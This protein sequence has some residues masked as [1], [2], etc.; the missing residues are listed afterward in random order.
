MMVVDWWWWWIWFCIDLHCEGVQTRS[1]ITV[2]E[3]Q[4]GGRRCPLPAVQHRSC[5]YTECFQWKLG[6]WKPCQTE[7]SLVYSFILTL[8]AELCYYMGS[9]YERQAGEPR[10]LKNWLSGFQW[11]II[12]I[13]N[14]MYACMYVCLSVCFFVIVSCFCY[15]CGYSEDHK[16]TVTLRWVLT[17]Q[18]PIIL[19]WRCLC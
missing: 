6:N 3:R 2:V 19:A 13:V 10:P 9:L 8:F 14:C 11:C 15:S 4:Y 17:G 16:V 7:A 1:R 12:I 18:C 5:A